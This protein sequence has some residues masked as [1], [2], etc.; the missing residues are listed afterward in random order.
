MDDLRKL[1]SIRNAQL[2]DAAKGRLLL[3]TD[4]QLAKKMQVSTTYTTRW[5]Q[6]APLNNAA[7]MWLAMTLNSNPLEL[8]AG[9]EATQTTGKEQEFWKDFLLRLAKKGAKWAGTA[10]AIMC[11]LIGPNGLATKGIDT[12]KQRRQRTP[13]A[14]T[15]NGLKPA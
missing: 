9:Y 7:L 1:R 2:L 13:K 14:R 5:R 8:L 15:K 6:G 3:S 12:L 11:L 4:Y 10:L